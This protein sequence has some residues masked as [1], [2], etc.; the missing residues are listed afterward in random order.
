MG[1]ICHICQKSAWEKARTDGVYRGDT[2]ASEGFIHC[3]SFEQVKAVADLFYRGQTNLLLLIIDEEKV[4][5]EIK[6][7]A[8]GAPE[9]YP[10]IYGPLN[11][12]AIVS[13]CEYEPD[14]EG[15]FPVFTG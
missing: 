10:H 7:E 15:C 8:L 5:A 3:S 6:W 9:D 4:E 11:L 12:S 2:L 13:T 14:D 1:K